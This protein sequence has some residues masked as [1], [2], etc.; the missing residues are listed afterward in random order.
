MRL[1]KQRLNT[2]L[3]NM[4]IIIP[5][6]LEKELLAEY[7]HPVANE[8]G[9]VIEYTEQDVYEQLRKRLRPYQSN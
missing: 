2:I 7:G 4:R 3:A 1:T 5:A 9:Y 8:G 6:G